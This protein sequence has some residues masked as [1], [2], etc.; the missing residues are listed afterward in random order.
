MSRISILIAGLI[1]LFMFGAPSQAQIVFDFNGTGGADT[2]TGTDGTDFYFTETNCTFN[3][4]C[5]VSTGSGLDFLVDGLGLTVTGLSGTS[6][7][8]DELVGTAA[9]VIED[10]VGGNGGLGVTSESGGSGAS[11]FDG[12]LE[13]TNFASTEAIIFSFSQQTVLVS[14]EMNNGSHADCTA[15]TCGTYD[16]WI[17][18]GLN[19]SGLTALDTVFG[20]GLIGTVF[21]FVSAS[22]GSGG[23]EQGF[24]IGGMSVV[25]EP[26]TWIMMILGF[27][28]IGLQMRRQSRIR[29][30]MA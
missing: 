23:A 29:V 2:P 1:S 27:G 30:E 25:P 21:T 14:V 26:A 13:Q 6:V 4:Y 15:I 16:L 17:D 8:S 5:S 22:A 7:V 11:G 3:D 18:G 20:A 19:S 12:S 10:L 9:H 24:Y 28:L